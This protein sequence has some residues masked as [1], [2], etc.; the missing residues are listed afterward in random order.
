MSQDVLHIKVEQNNL[1]AFPVVHVNDIAKLECP[2]EALLRK[3]GQV[4]IY[5]FSKKQEGERGR[6]CISILKIMQMIHSEYPA[7]QIENEGEKDI[8]LC[9]VPQKRKAPVIKWAK[10]IFLC[11]L[12]FFGAAFTIMAFNNDIS[13]N[14]LFRQIYSQ[15]TGRDMGI[16]TELQVGYAIGMMVG[17]LIFFNHIGIRKMTSDPTPVQVEMRKYEQDVNNTFIENTSRQGKNIDV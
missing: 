9:Y 3:I 4:V 11:I 1:L 10:T 12:L 16:M 7:V 17:I 14:E 6:V 2:N 5:R 8:I 15:V 13:V